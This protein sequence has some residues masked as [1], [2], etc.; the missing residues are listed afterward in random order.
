MKT[1]DVKEL[2]ISDE[3]KCLQEKLSDITSTLDNYKR[4]LKEESFPITS[5]LDLLDRHSRTL[6]ELYTKVTGMTGE[7]CK[8]DE[9]VRR[10]FYDFTYH[11]LRSVH[12]NLSARAADLQSA[13]PTM[14]EKE[15][16]TLKSLLSYQKGREKQVAQLEKLWIGLF[17]PVR[18]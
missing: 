14:R 4:E 18:K 6:Q 8:C 11:S 10:N 5:R 13:E 2:D 9:V 12:N 16:E 7:A 1:S 3:L 15:K 17:S